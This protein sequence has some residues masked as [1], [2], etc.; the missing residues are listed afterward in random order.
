VAEP[1]P[2]RLEDDGEPEAEHARAAS[3]M[4]LALKALSQRALAAIADLF[5]LSTMAAAFWLFMSIPNPNVYQ[6]VSEAMF[7]IFV[8]TANWIVRR[9]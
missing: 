5:F 9:K 3:A 1:V 6:L 2:F 8:L 4:M 7:S